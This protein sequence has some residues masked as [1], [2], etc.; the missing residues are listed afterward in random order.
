MEIDD[1][2]LPFLFSA[3]LASCIDLLLYIGIILTLSIQ[4]TQITSESMHPYHFSSEGDAWLCGTLTPYRVVASSAW[5]L[6]LT[7][8]VVSFRYPVVGRVLIRQPAER[9]WAD[10]TVLIEYLVHA[11]GTST[12]NTDQHRW[13]V[14]QHKPGKDFYD[15]QNRCLSTGPVYNPHK[16]CVNSIVP[17]SVKI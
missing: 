7:T 16:V 17:Q 12:N 2:M 14:H 15:W 10:S 11:D 13:A 4:L 6:P 1:G 9:H 3:D 5:K 8:A